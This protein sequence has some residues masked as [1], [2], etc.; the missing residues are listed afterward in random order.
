MREPGGAGKESQEYKE[1]GETS[2]SQRESSLCLHS[3]RGGADRSPGDVPAL[4]NS[5][6]IHTFV[7][8]NGRKVVVHSDYYR[9]YG[10]KREEIVR[11]VIGADGVD[12]EK[13]WKKY[14]SEKSRLREF[15]QTWLKPMLDDGVFVRDGGR[16]LPAPDW[17][18]AL[19]QV[20]MRTDEDEDNRLQSEKY[21]ERRRRYLQAKDTPGERV[22]RLPGKEKNRQTF[23]N[24]E[25]RDEAARIEEQRSK[26]GVTVEVFVH[27][28]LKRLGRASMGLL[29][30]LWADEGGNPSHVW[31]AVRRIGC[32][33]ERLPEYDNSLLVYPPEVSKPEPEPESVTQLPRPRSNG[34]ATTPRDQGKLAIV[35]PIY[36]SGPASA[37]APEEWKDHPLDCECLDCSCAPRSYARPYRREEPHYA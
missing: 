15:R 26:V 8:E 29:R 3:T 31:L 36:P 7:Y 2:L 28:T 27:D 12:E 32:K 30:D 14:G 16:I 9:R 34:R 5:K 4:R 25:E 10:S 23:Q 35:T 33:L 22:P 19:E 17:L 21:A 37:P 24:M 6:L 11:Y 1:K 13:L 18:G 20:R